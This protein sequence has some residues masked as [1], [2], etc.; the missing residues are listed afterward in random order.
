MDEKDEQFVAYFLPTEKTLM[1][2]HKDSRENRSY[3]EKYEYE[4]TLAREYNWNVKNQ[5]NKS[6]EQNFFFVER[7]DGI[8]YNQLETR[9]FIFFFIL[10]ITN[11]FIFNF[12]LLY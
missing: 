1:K 3:D 5:K 8:Y 11:L 4:Y 6:L 12:N 10:Y 2:Q 7:S 9:L